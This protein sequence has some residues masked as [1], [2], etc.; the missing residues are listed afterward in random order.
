M[1]DQ[2]HIGYA[3]WQQPKENII[4]ELKEISVPD[5]P[6]MGVAVEGSEDWWPHAKDELVLPELDVYQQQMHTIEVFNRGKT[7]FEYQVEAGAPWLLVAPARGTI[8]KECRLSVSVNWEQVPSG[9]HRVPITITGQRGSQVI[10]QVAIHNPMSPKRSEM[11]G[12]IEGNGYVSME[13]EHYSRAVET[14]SVRWQHI[15]NLGRTLSAMTP[16]P[17]TAPTQLPGGDSPRL[18]YRMYLFHTGPVQVQTYISPTLDFH[19]KQGLRYAI[20]FDDETP[21]VVNI[22]TDNS[23]EAW[24]RAVSDNIKIT[25]SKHKLDGPGVHVLKFWMVDPGVVLEKIVVDTGDLRPSYLGPPESFYR[26]V[27]R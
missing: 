26:A 3:T 20:S 24:M 27:Q 11:Q 1:M 7:P 4:P 19:N 23:N 6:E 18:E 13:A 8:E 2:T 21:Q 10:I 25:V 22:W 14:E 5:A 12:F 9:T 16:M 17:V 15:P